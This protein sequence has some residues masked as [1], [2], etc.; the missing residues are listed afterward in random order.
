MAVEKPS[1]KVFHIASRVA[2]NSKNTK[3]KLCSV[4]VAQVSGSDTLRVSAVLSSAA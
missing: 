4:S 2:E 1:R 3:W